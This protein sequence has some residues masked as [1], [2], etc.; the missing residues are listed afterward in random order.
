[1]SGLNDKIS[2]EEN[3]ADGKVHHELEYTFYGEVVR[4]SDLEKA[5]EKEE[6]EQWVVPIENDED[7]VEARV[8]IRAV[9]N[10]RWLLT[11]KI[12][13]KGMLGWEEISHDISQPLFNHLREMAINGYKKT[14][15]TFKIE[16]SELNW[17]VDV[18]KDL[19]GQPHPWVK[20][21]LEVK[22]KDDDISKYKLPVPFRQ[23]I[24]HQKGDLDEK[25][26][27]WVDNLWKHQWAGLD[28]A[29]RT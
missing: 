27:A 6:H 22:S 25:E 4:L 15:Y 3:N 28:K 23:I 9:D 10:R 19:N 2:L 11:T 26:K 13:R 21:D 20:I 24:Q 12:K 17:E 18:F 5:Q 7:V 1:M 14:R 29:Q 8:R 16:G